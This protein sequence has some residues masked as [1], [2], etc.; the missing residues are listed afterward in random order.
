MIK[1]GEDAVYNR[2][3][4]VKLALEVLNAQP[5]LLLPALDGVQIAERICSMAET[6]I[7][8]ITEGKLPVYQ[9]LPV[10]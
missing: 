2:Q 4:A 9:D 6:F 7:P 3:E 10:Q 1:K 5:G 8:Y